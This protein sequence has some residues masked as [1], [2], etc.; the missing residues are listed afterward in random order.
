ML[1]SDLEKVKDFGYKVITKAS[2]MLTKMSLRLRV[3]I[4]HISGPVSQESQQIIEV[5]YC[6]K[7]NHLNQT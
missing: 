7:C 1:E 4:T 2:T 6:I 5:L 3:I